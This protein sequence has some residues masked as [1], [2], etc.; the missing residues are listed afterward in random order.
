MQSAAKMLLGR[1]DFAGFQNVGSPQADT[2]RTL[3]SITD[4]LPS[5][6]QTKLM[7]WRF[8]G[9]GFLKQMVRNLMGFMVWAG[10]G[11][12]QPEDARRVFESKNR[13]T[14]DFPTAP[15]W[16]LTLSDVIY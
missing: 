6:A 1:H 3:R 9:D 10:Q 14:V 11:K 5:P 2:V 16:G 7:A 13:R 12:L 15:A 4:F 8:Y